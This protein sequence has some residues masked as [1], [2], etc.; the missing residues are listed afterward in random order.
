MLFVDVHPDIIEVLPNILDALVFVVLGFLRVD[1]EERTCVDVID[2]AQV[3]FTYHWVAP[4]LVVREDAASSVELL[5]VLLILE[6]HLVYLTLVVGLVLFDALL[7][8]WILDSQLGEVDGHVIVQ[9]LEGV[10]YQ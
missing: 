10:V 2:L 8:Q 7:N 5:L 1:Q 9:E 3:H 6:D 4:V